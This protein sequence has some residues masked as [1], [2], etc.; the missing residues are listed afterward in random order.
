MRP[1]EI[2]ALRRGQPNAKAAGL[3]RDI[4]R[5][6]FPGLC[7][8]FILA[9]RICFALKKIFFVMVYFNIVSFKCLCVGCSICTWTSSQSMR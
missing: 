7:F 3:Q 1:S 4:R 6:I 9:F 5:S 2:P 8:A